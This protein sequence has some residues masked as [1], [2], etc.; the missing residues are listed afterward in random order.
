[1]SVNQSKKPFVQKSNAFTAGRIRFVPTDKF[2]EQQKIYHSQLLFHKEKLRALLESDRASVNGIVMEVNFHM[3]NLYTK[4]YSIN[5]KAGDVDNFLKGLIDAI[6]Q[7]V[8]S[9]DS[10]IVKII[11]SKVQSK[12]EKIEVK[13]SENLR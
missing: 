8:Q 5:K 3:T 7:M 6:F 10:V 4:K 2:K 11:A 1:M 12:E 13:L 9:D